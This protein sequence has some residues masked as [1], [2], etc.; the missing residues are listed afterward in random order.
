MSGSEWGCQEAGEGMRGQAVI[1]YTQ[2]E[3]ATLG[4]G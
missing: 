1:P 2:L 4:L 3:L